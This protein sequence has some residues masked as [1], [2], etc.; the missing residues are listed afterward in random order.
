MLLSMGDLERVIMVK[1]P[2]ALFDDPFIGIA[3]E[4]A[5]RAECEALITLAEPH[6][7]VAKVSGEDGSFVTSGRTAKST[8][9]SYSSSDLV[10]NIGERIASA[11]E[12]PLGHAE[13]M[14]IVRYNLGG[15]YRPHFD[16]YDLQTDRGKF[17]TLK[18]GQRLC[19]AL[20]YLN[21]VQIGGETAFPKIGL[22]I[23]PRSGSLLIFSNCRAA[24]NQIHPKSLHASLPAKS[25]EKWVA[26][27]WFRE[28]L[29]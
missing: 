25:G 19:T 11:A 7:A 10:R 21:D 6:L 22:L 16:S 20:L 4:F 23:P 3:P 14:Q 1:V 29:Q 24:T 28:R 12:H 8:W 13:A 26:T 27:I 5:T 9:I 2:S 17:N 15:E 18:R